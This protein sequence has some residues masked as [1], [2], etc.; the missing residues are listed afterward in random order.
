MAQMMVKPQVASFLNAM[1]S[2]EGP[3][4]EEILVTAACGAVGRTIGE[5]DIGS[6]T[7]A[8]ILAVRKADGL[9]LSPNKDT[10]LEESDVIVGAGS[11]EEITKLERMFEPRD[12]IVAD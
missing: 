12:A 11:A 7:G 5:L 9:E 8:Q 2:A 4:F 1:T 10:V 3:S 6:V